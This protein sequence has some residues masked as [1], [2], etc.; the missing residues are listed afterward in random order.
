MSDRRIARV[1]LDSPLPQLDRLFDYAIPD[2]FADAVQPGVRVRV[3]L[4]VAGRVVDGFVASVDSETDVER[5]LS[6]VDDVVSPVAVMPPR[7]YELARR[8]A[9]RAA[10]SV[11]DVLRVAVPR[12]MARA[13]KTWLSR[14]PVSASA[15]DA[16]ATEWAAAV[17]SAYPT[18]PDALA[19]GSRMALSAIAEPA[20]APDGSAAGRWSELLAA[21]A[22]ATL[23]D[24]RSAVL[25]VPDY[26]DLSQLEAMLLS[27]VP[28]PALVR[29][30]A[31]QNASERYAAYLRTLEPAPVIVI[32]NRSAVYAPVERLGLLAIWDDGDPLLREPLSPG[33]HARDAAL[34]RHE[35]DGGAL[36]FAAH[37]RSTDVERLVG[38]GWLTQIRPTRATHPR[39]LLSPLAEG[40]SPGTRVPAAAFAAAR[41]AL[42]TGPVLV[43]VARPGYAPVLTC[44]SCRQPARCAN[45]AGPLSARGRGSVPQCRVCGRRADA[46]TCTHCSGTQLRLIGSGSERTAEELGR[47]FPGTRVIVSDGAH[48]LTHVDAGPA[49]VIATRGAEPVAP[50]GYHAV[51]LLDGERMLLAE[52]LRIAE[53]CLR[54]WSNASAL[55]APGAPVHLVGVTGPLGRALAT[56]TQPLFARAELGERTPLRMPPAVRVASIEG[57]RTAV[58]ATITATRAEVPLEPTA[59]LGPIE[60]AHGWRALVRFDYQQGAAVAR[61]LRAAVVDAAVRARRPRRGAPAAASTLRVRLDLADISL[62]ENP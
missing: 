56:W 31:A 20:T 42:S 12:R 53:H 38:L 18:L 17:L 10:G 3:P 34:L 25:V 15:P 36:L 35:H 21:A 8:A 50:G 40:E 29:L 51:L 39:I 30:D 2:Q 62:E 5:A 33:I 27:R 57:P 43:Q 19:S 22:I 26:R 48:T 46:W 24:G 6:E 11:I 45:C 59:V 55:A 28:A 44:A 58:E 60:T 54:W 37:T 9:D 41:A 47:A 13:E 49:L 14:G 61:A 32:G 16:A 1:V 4:R 7:L 23:R 52:D